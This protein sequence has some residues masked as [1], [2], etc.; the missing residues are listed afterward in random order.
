MKVSFCIRYETTPGENVFIAGSWDK[1]KKFIPMAW[2][3]GG[4]WTC[5]I[6]LEGEKINEN[7]CMI[8]YKYVVVNGPNV[9]WESSDNRTV[10]LPNTDN[11]FVIFMD[12]WNYPLCTKVVVPSRLAFEREKV[13]LLRRRNLLRRVLFVTQCTSNVRNSFAL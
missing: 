1:W 11:S 5:S 3:K 4:L 7:V 10:K 13:K 9:T 12:T 2:S 8:E 6:T